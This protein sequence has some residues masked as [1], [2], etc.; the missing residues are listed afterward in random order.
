MKLIEKFRPWFGRKSVRGAI[1]IIVLI[2]VILVV[3]TGSNEDAQT[4][5]VPLTVVKLT[6]PI[7]YVGSQTLSLIGSVRAFTEADITT[8]RSGR[9]TSVNLGL[10]QEVVAG[11]VLATLENAAES[12]AVLQAEGVYDAAVAAAAQ[13]SVGVDEATNSLE[14]SRNSAVS[15]FKSAYNTTN[16]AIVNTIDVFFASPNGSVPGLRISGKGFTD[17]LNDQRVEF[18]TILPTWQARVNTISSQSDLPSELRYATENIQKAINM[19]DIFLVILN[20]QSNSNRYTDAE[21]TSFSTTFTTLRTSLINTQSSID[22]A[23]TGLDSARDAVRRAELS[24]TG[25]A[26]SAA[27]AQ[28]KQALGSLR[29]AQANYAKTILS[30]PI[31]G[32]INSLGVR[33][34]DFINSF[35]RIA[36]VANNNALEIITY[37]SDS[38]KSLI[39]E[40]DIV[41]IEDEFEGVV[42]NVAPA[43]DPITS[44]TEVRIATEGIDIRNGD[45]VRISKQ[46]DGSELELETIRIPLTAV[47]FDRDNGFIFIVEDGSLVS[48][49]VE[50]SRVYGDSVEVLVGMENDTEFVL[51]VRG[52]VEGEVV[53]IAE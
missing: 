36:V 32:T 10:G 50:L 44:K 18:Q 6:T 3:A 51:D 49:E 16:G 12:A 28:V 34:G 47:K 14:K 1:F 9:V 46:S 23:L 19:V 52:L 4:A 31:S 40:G 24:S 45:T 7:E 5:E 15:A 29:A 30:T 53:E 35:S 39:R 20:Q 37:I 26:N 41:M 48:K 21:L 33:K 2:M 11:T 8:E 25:G 13:S 43:V 17:E 22:T 42:T 38:E 27:D